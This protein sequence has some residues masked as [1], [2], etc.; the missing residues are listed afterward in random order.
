MAALHF[1]P[2]TVKLSEVS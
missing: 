1:E 2:A